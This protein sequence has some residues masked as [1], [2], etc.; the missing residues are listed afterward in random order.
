MMLDCV[1]VWYG[2]LALTRTRYASS[3]ALVLGA[4]FCT[5]GFVLG[6]VMA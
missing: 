6:F 5:L 3:I 1:A 4:T 2:S